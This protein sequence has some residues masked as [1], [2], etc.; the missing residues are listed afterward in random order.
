ME[1]TTKKIQK[2]LS[3]LFLLFLSY[4]VLLLLPVRM[5][6]YSWIILCVST[7]LF[8]IGAFWLG[9]AFNAPAGKSFRTGKRIFLRAVCVLSCAFAVFLCWA[10][11]LSD[12]S[13]IAGTL[14]LIEG[15]TAWMLSDSNSYNAMM[16]GMKQVTSM[17]LPI[18][19]IFR[20][21]EQVD[22]PLGRPW[23]GK[24]R[25]IEDDCLIYGPTQAGSFVYCWYH[26]G[27]FTV[28]ECDDVSWLDER[29]AERHRVQ[30]SW[31]RDAVEM[32][33]LYHLTAMLLPDFYRNMFEDYA[34]RHTA[35][36]RF[37]DTFRELQP[38]VYIFNEQFAVIEQDYELQDLNGNVRYL[39]HGAIPF[40][41]FTLSDA[42]S[43]EE[44]FRIKRC[45][46][47]A[48]PHYDIYH[49]G[50]KYGSVARQFDLTHETFKMETADGLLELREFNAT[51]GDQFVAYLDGRLIGTISERLSLTVRD[52]VYENFILM[53]FESQY[54]PLLAV[55]TVMLQSF[56][57]NSIKG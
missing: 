39:L 1:K 28:G 27:C 36:C 33:Q 21:F 44:V 55:L 9:S 43:G 30:T 19:E 17:S 23:M 57:D 6:F 34:V 11:R 20:A 40:L 13:A 5:R 12:R 15:I 51:V 3:G 47:H 52:F 18:E 10:D 14:L 54:V 4:G 45:L 35:E 22:T 16:D 37:L 24:V 8:C 56:K 41:T 53:A 50:E 2:I 32:G 29:E 38:D 48:L 46:V 42:D 31:D 26:T 7:L 49:Y 25:S